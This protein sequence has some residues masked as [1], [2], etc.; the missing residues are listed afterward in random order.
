[1]TL[2]SYTLSNIKITPLSPASALATYRVKVDGALNGQPFNTN[3]DV[4]QVFVKRGGDW[5]ELRYHES[6]SK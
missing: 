1:M 3:L 2:N 5:K 6:E 4:T